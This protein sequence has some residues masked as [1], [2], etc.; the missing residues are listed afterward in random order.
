MSTITY[1]HTSS[2]IRTQTHKNKQKRNRSKHIVAEIDKMRHNQ[3]IWGARGTKEGQPHP[4]TIASSKKNQKIA[5]DNKRQVRITTTSK[6]SKQKV[7]TFEKNA[8]LP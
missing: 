6:K 1:E 8:Y 3:G 4:K 7:N 2:K 5:K